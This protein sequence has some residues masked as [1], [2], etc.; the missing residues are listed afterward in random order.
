[1]LPRI[2]ALA[3]LTLSTGA[4]ARLRP[5]TPDTRRERAATH[6]TFQ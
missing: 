1:M 3:L 5:E 6:L 2:A 4:L